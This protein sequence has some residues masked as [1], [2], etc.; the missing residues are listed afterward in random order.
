MSEIKLLPC[1]FCGGEVRLMSVIDD[2]E[3]CINYEDELDMN[4]SFI[5]CCNCDMDF[6]P[7][8]ETARE[9]LESWNTRKPMERII[10]KVQERQKF[11]KEIYNENE[12]ELEWAIS[13][14]NINS[15]ERIKAVQGTAIEAYDY[16]L[17]VVKEEGGI[18]E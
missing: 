15:C 10:K 4:H 18:S 1:P 16:S 12:K 17:A 8:M 9:V 7:H 3:V 5:H 6:I 11:H 13:R 2:G 14:F